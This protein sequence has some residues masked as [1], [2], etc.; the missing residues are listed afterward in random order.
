VT[1]G[2]TLAAGAGSADPDPAPPVIGISAYSAE[3]AW[4]VWRTEAVLLPR[5]YVDAVVRAGGLPVLL[6]PLPE[7]IAGMLSRLDGLILAGGPDV[8]PVRYGQAMGPNTQPPKPE[9]DAAE[10]ALFERAMDDDLPVLGICRGMQLINVARG[11]TLHQHLPDVLGDASHAPE[12]GVFSSHPVRV[13]EGSRTA[14]VLGR[15]DVDGVPSYHHQAIDVLGKGLV[16]TAWAPD[17]MPEALEDP[18]AAFCVAVQWHPEEGA[19]PALF[20]GLVTA[21]RVRAAARV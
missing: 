15:T 21:A 20:D 19:D 5:T 3:A 9:R 13:A 12:L 1:Q 8:E 7:V 10:L 11:G 14:A 17:G 6:P 18:S 16:A 2:P 4:G